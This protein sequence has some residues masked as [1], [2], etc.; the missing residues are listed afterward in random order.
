MLIQ[1]KNL[2]E[3]TDR[4]L[5]ADFA[6]AGFGFQTGKGNLFHPLEASYL[7]SIGKT[8]YAKKPASSKSFAFASAVY[9]QIRGT[10]R[11]IRPY[12]KSGD[13]F[14][15]Y[16]P[17]VG[18]E[19]KRPSQ[20]VALLPGA[21]PSAASLAKQ[22][23]VAHLARLDLIIACGTEKEIKYYKISSYNW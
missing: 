10:G 13:Y 19:E 15:V 8:S 6:E 16:E 21:P 14:R 20:L 1:K 4:R 3:E 22:V 11:A 17:G 7:V 9:S 23:K 2:F 5:A 12:M 18:R